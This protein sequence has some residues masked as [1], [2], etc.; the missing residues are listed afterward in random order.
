M[1]VDET[2]IR[3]RSAIRPRTLSPGEIGEN[4]GGEARDSPR[5]EFG[6]YRVAEP[7]DLPAGNEQDYQPPA[8]KSDPLP[9]TGR[10]IPGLCPI[11]QPAEHR[12]AAD[13]FRD[14]GFR[15]RGVCLFRP[16]AAPLLAFHA[17]GSG[18]VIELRFVESVTTDVRIE[19]RNLDDIHYWISE[20]CMPWVWEQPKGFKSTADTVIT[21]ITFLPVEQEVEAS[22]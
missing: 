9:R 17:P 21:R 18:P 15:V 5:P 14:Q 6:H 22:S 3:N 10:A 12:S 19:G 7:E 20:G 11:S 2:L 13:P 4:T 1:A 8:K 16:A